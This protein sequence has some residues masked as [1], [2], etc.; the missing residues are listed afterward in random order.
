MPSAFAWLWLATSWLLL[1]ASMTNCY[2]IIL[3]KQR[4]MVVLAERWGKHHTGQINS[5]CGPYVWQPWTRWYHYYGDLF[6]TNAIKVPEGWTV[7]GLGPYTAQYFYKMFGW[8]RKGKDYQ[9]CRRHSGRGKRDNRAH[10]LY[11]ISRIQN[12]VNR[13]NWT[14]YQTTWCSTKTNVKSC[15]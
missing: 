15:T 14:P 10:T 13:L 11:D 4:F 12:D 7:L 2:S 6:P 1:L 9:I 3:S 8:G 5:F